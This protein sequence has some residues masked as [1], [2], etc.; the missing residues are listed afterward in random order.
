VPRARAHSR[1][2]AGH[3]VFT[4]ANVANRTGAGLDLRSCKLN[5]VDA[6][7]FCGACHGTCWDVNLGGLTGL[8]NVRAQPYRLEKSRCWKKRGD[9]RLTCVA[10]HDPHR[11]LV[12]DSASYDRNCLSCHLSTNSNSPTPEHPGP[13][14]KVSTK[15]CASCHMPKFEDSG[16]HYTFTD[17]YIRVVRPGAPYPD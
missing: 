13:P 17:H 9:A 6:V 12:R 15:N 7:D 10:C 14:C 1:S 4:S 3:G 16:M 11:E 5:P 2:R 8:A